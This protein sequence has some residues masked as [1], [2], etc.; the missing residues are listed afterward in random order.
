MYYNQGPDL[1]YESD[2][3]S[4]SDESDDSNYDR[5]SPTR[6]NS[7]QTSSRPE[8][9]YE[10]VNVVLSIRLDRMFNTIKLR[11]LQDLAFEKTDIYDRYITGQLT[12]DENDLLSMLYPMQRDE[13]KYQKLRKQISHHVEV[14][15]SKASEILS[16]PCTSSSFPLSDTSVVDPLHNLSLG[17]S[18]VELRKRREQQ[19]TRPMI[20][21][22]ALSQSW[23]GDPINGHVSTRK[24]RHAMFKLKQRKY[25]YLRPREMSTKLSPP[26]TIKVKKA[27]QDNR[28]EQQL[29]EK[30]TPVSVSDLLTTVISVQK[31]QRKLMI[32]KYSNHR[33]CACFIRECRKLKSF[34]LKT[35]AHYISR[36]LH[37][38]FCYVRTG[39]RLKTTEFLHKVFAIWLKASAGRS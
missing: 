6:H 33:Q 16:T 2:F 4:D 27:S 9:D 26:T 8:C 13:A 39:F 17:E 36:I 35:L 12:E 20:L 11:P 14:L 25:H 24:L 38:P 1:V 34:N 7:F 23:I 15:D 37:L 21:E 22:E 3:Q 10:R 18:I 5:S 32:K 31:P 19:H 30:P 29:V 28:S